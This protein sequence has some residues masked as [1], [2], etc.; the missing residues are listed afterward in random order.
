MTYLGLH[1]ADGKQLIALDPGHTDGPFLVTKVDLGAVD[2]RDDVIDN[3]SGDGTIDNTTA[4]GASAVTVELT[5]QGTAARKASQWL[6]DLRALCHPSARNYLHL[7]LDEWPS[8]RRL[9]VRGAGAPRDLT[10][11][12]PD[13]QFQWKAPL[14]YLEDVVESSATRL[15]TGVTVPGLH[16]PVS[17]PVSTGN[18][19]PGGA[20]PFI[21]GGGVRPWW[22]LDIYGACTAPRLTFGDDEWAVAF[23]SDLVVPAGHFVRITPQTSS[24]PQVTLDGDS[25]NDLYGALDFSRTSWRRLVVGRNAAVLTANQYSAGFRA[26]LRWRNR[27][28]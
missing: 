3:P 19:S 10:D 26:V 28:P 20:V 8:G 16:A 14:G 11:L 9:L 6:D 22:E 18:A 7:K 25:D 15:P 5:V 1:D 27:W 17:A 24:G 12:Q 4:T 13:V 21:V 23:T 2:V